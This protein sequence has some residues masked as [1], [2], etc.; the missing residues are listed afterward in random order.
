MLQ[1]DIP[2]LMDALHV[3]APQCT[4][5]ILHALAYIVS[6]TN[7]LLILPSDLSHSNKVVYCSW[8]ITLHEF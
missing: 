5:Y 1:V 2:S 6:Y 3:T 7:T 8:E 4:R